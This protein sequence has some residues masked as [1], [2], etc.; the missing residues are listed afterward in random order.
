MKKT[1]LFF[2]LL[3]VSISSFSQSAPVVQSATTTVTN[4]D[5]RFLLF[6]TKNNHIFLK[7]DTSNGKIWMVQFSTGD[8]EALELPLYSYLYPL[9]TE[10]EQQNGRFYLYQTINIYNFLLIDQIDGRVWQVQWH[11]DSDKRI[12]SR[13]E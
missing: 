3:L 12:I 13:I 8:T 2:L 11:P 10:T 7:L 1:L 9:V 6:Q 5:A 4:K